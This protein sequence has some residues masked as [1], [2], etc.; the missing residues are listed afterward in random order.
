M[1]ADTIP[2]G[3]LSG[4]KIHR[5]RCSDCVQANRDYETE[6][7]R[8]RRAGLP[9]TN[10]IDGDQ[11]RAHVMALHNA[12]LTRARIATA[13]GVKLGW[14]HHVMTGRPG[15]GIVPSRR[16]DAVSGRRVLAL[17]I[18]DQVLATDKPV[19]GDGA[20]WR[21][22]ALVAIGYPPRWQAARIGMANSHYREWL[23]GTGRLRAS[24]V[25]AINELYDAYWDKPCPD[26]GMACEARLLAE[27]RGF[28]LPMELEDD[29]IDLP[30]DEMWAELAA[31]VKRMSRA[32]L[33]RCERA[34]A[35]G[36]RSL[37][38]EAA[39]KEMGRLKVAD[40]RERW[41]AA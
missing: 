20:R 9:T 12:G 39:V 34:F 3:E 38:V 35:E 7:R 14:L 41:V 24:R 15:D 40:K 30:V 21:A 13:A 11:V 36:D 4:Y 26:A 16:V 2:H 6:H 8:R 10:R 17:P 22:G 28:R 29:V 19:P 5:C 37:M 31:R 23:F 1:G 32:E 27:Q 33:R 18:P 25:R